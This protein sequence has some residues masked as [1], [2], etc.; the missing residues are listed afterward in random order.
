MRHNKLNHAAGM[1]LLE[2]MVALVVFSLAAIAI[3]QSLSTQVKNMPLIERKMVAQWVANNQMVETHLKQQR[4]PKQL[5]SDAKNRGQTA[6]LFMGQIWYWEEEI[7]TFPEQD[8][9]KEVII[10][11]SDASDYARI[12]AELHSYVASF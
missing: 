8:G 2:V 7:T 11:V 5:L 6:E 4:R 10:R 1:T 12:V 3:V 9:V